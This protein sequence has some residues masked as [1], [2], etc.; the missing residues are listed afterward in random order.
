MRTKALT[1]LAA[2]AGVVGVAGLALAQ[3]RAT[4][5]Q[6]TLVTSYEACT[7]SGNSTNPTT[8][9]GWTACNAVRSDSSCGFDRG[10]ERKV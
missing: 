3:S 8:G 1:F 2:T 4:P 7:G 5:L 9:G 6:S 10:G